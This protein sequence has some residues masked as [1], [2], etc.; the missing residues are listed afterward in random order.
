MY[1][2]DRVWFSGLGF[3]F[4]VFISGFFGYCFR[5]RGRIEL[6]GSATRAPKRPWIA[7]RIRTRFGFSGPG[8]SFLDEFATTAKAKNS[9]LG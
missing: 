6:C 9:F 7:K 2:P 4:Q 8:F 5:A 1:H 3:G